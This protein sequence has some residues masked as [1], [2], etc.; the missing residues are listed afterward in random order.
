MMDADNIWTNGIG[1]PLPA[2]PNLFGPSSVGPILCEAN[3]GQTLVEA[4]FFW[5][6]DAFWM[7]TVRKQ[8]SFRGLRGLHLFWTHP[9]V[10][11]SPKTIVL[12]FLFLDCRS[13]A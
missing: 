2:T 12:L 5:F 11:H 3:T 13:E 1:F 9:S 7:A 4:S 6:G 8:A 10:R